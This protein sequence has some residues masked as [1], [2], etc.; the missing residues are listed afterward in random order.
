[1]GISIIDLVALAKAGY[2]PKQVKE[3]ISL[4]ET[5]DTVKPEEPQ[6]AT[7][8]PVEPI[9]ASPEQFTASEK[10]EPAAEPEKKEDIDYKSLYEKTAEDLKKAQAV[11]RAQEV[12]AE[13]PNKAMKDLQ[14]TIR[15]Y[16]K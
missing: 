6:G 9:S 2:S 13:D 7:P 5:A 11:N 3:L 14:D 4:S 15:T 10:E 8:A 12:P 16:F 1:M